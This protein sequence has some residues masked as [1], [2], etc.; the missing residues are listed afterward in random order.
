MVNT[1][2][3]LI[4]GLILMVV[5]NMCTL[6]FILYR[7]FHGEF[8]DIVNRHEPSMGPLKALHL[9][10]EQE[11]VMKQLKSDLDLKMDSLRERADELRDRQFK[12]LKGD[13]DNSALANSQ[14]EEIG[15]CFTEME[16]LLFN[17]FSDVKKILTKEQQAQF[18][19]FT[20]QM[21]KRRMGPPSF[22]RSDCDHHCSPKKMSAF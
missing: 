14:A 13:T 9:T 17:H 12:L 18:Y 7:P 6:G 11:D 22:M 10:A 2:K 1:Q 21:G 5:L 20:E 19:K 16:K 15:K 3:L 4:G 8:D